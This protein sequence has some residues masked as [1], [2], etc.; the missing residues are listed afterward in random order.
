M[1]MLGHLIATSGNLLKTKVIFG[2][3]PLALNWARLLAL[4]PVTL[5][6]IIET[7][8]RNRLIRDKLDEEWRITYQAMSKH[9]LTTT[10]E[11]PPGDADDGLA[12]P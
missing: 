8:K 9:S 11:A 5:A 10:R 3:N 1:L 12:E 7:L 6:W 4:P 2:M